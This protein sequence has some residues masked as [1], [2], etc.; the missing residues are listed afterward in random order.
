MRNGNQILRGKLDEIKKI[1]QCRPDLPILAHALAKK[2]V[3]RMLTRDLFALANLFNARLQEFDGYCT[4]VFSGSKVANEMQKKQN[5]KMLKRKQSPK[6]M[7]EKDYYKTMK[8]KQYS[9]LKIMHKA[10]HSL[11]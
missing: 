8:K 7:K 1:L 10:F 6:M 9:P 4:S 5:Y 2:I 3:T 11:F